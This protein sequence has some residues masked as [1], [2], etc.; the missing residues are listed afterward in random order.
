MLP[1]STEETVAAFNKL[2]TAMARLLPETDPG[3][4]TRKSLRKIN[5]FVRPKTSL[6]FQYVLQATKE[7]MHTSPSASI[8]RPTRANSSLS[9]S[10]HTVEV[11]LLGT[12]TPKTIPAESCVQRPTALWSP[13][14]TEPVLALRCPHRS[15]TTKTPMIGSFKTQTR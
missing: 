3:I 11:S 5:H 2:C 10:S 15:T 13:S 6:V 7:S 4:T 9:F 14:T 12:W 1:G 8:T